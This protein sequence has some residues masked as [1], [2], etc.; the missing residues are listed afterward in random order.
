MFLY[1][2]ATNS[3]RIFLTSYW[4]RMSVLW[5]SS[6]K[7][8]KCYLLCS[9]VYCFRQKNLCTQ[10]WVSNKFGFIFDIDFFCDTRLSN[11]A[12]TPEIYE[13]Q[14]N[15]VVISWL[16]GVYAVGWYGWVPPS[17][18]DQ[19]MGMGSKNSTR[20]VFYGQNLFVS[21]QLPSKKSLMDNAKINFW[22]KSY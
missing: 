12:N 7:R 4:R 9:A 19:L 5:R 3:K 14:L 21:V 10:I 16:R 2:F 15:R 11:W 13:I 18:Q 22:M 6:R 17:F 1:L 20:C 8:K